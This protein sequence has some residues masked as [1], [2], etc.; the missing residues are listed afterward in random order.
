MTGHSLRR[1][2]RAALLALGLQALLI[3]LA[4]LLLWVTGTAM[5]M[6]AVA[7]LLGG[8]ISLLPNLWFALRVLVTPAPLH[9]PQRISSLYKAEAIKL[10]LVVVL[11]ML[12]FAG[13]RSVPA[14]TVLA[15]F[16]LTHPLYLLL[17]GWLLTRMEAGQSGAGRDLAHAQTKPASNQDN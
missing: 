5:H 17:Q 16:V 15:A 9:A 6:H 11:F 7:V 10:L 1:L 3:M 8:A 4:A 14:A 2:R 13:M 12:V